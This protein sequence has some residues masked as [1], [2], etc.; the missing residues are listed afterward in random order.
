MPSA[1]LPE[2]NRAR[3]PET[4]PQRYLECRVPLR[5]LAKGADFDFSSAA[6][7]SGLAFEVCDP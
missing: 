7:R 5:F 6:P 1:T 2:P 4:E 3:G